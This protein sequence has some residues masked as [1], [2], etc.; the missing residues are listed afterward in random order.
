M[1]SD[2][3]IIRSRRKTISLQIDE[4]LQVT[5][6]APLRMPDSAVREFIEEKTP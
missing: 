1:I 2:I 5:L 3:R 6:R 4:K